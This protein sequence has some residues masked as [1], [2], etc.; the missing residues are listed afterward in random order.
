MKKVDFPMHNA[1]R[2]QL[3]ELIAE[4]GFSL[5]DNP[6]RCEAL[7]KDYCGQYKR[8]IA[9]LVAV[10]DEQIPYKIIN[11][12]KNMPTHILKM[13]LIKEAYENLGIASDFAEWAIDSWELALADIKNS[14]KNIEAKKGDPEQQNRI[15]REYQMGQVV[16]QNDQEAVKWYRL[17]A[18][19]GNSSGQS[20]LGSMYQN[21]RGV[22]QSDQEAVKWYRLAAEQGN[23]FGQSNLGSMYRD[24]RGVP[25]SDQEAVKWYQRAAEQGYAAAQY[26]LGLIYENSMGTNENQKEALKWYKK[27]AKQGHAAAKNKL[28]EWEIDYAD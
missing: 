26:N 22:P 24:G 21:G 19:Q 7:L 9:V 1:P 27:A 28:D 5:C 4:Y 14:Q 13:R 10:M 2:R 8:E 6:R 23:S 25:Q 11:F 15:G 18:E 16:Q 20:N 12:Q 3:F 17:A